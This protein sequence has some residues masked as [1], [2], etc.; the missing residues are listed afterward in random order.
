MT[1]ATQAMRVANVQQRTPDWHVWRRQGV[2]AS[3]A[4]VLTG[5]SK[6]RSPWDYNTPWGLWA[7]AIGLL[8]E[9]DLSGNPNIQR[10]I[11]LEPK[12]R[13]AVEWE[14]KN[15]GSSVFSD[16]LNLE[17]GEYDLLPVCGESVEEPFM[18]ASLDGLVGDIP[19]ELKCP[20]QNVWNDVV[21]NRERSEAV[22]MYWAQLQHQLFV[23]GGQQGVLFFYGDAM[24][25]RMFVFDRDDSFIQNELLPA[26]RDL[27]KNIQECT[28]PDKDPDL[29]VWHP[30]GEDLF[31]WAEV[32]NRFKARRQ[33]VKELEQ[34]LKALK[35]SMRNDEQAL[36]ELMGSWAAAEADG[37]RVRRGYRRGS[38]DWKG[39][40]EELH[41]DGVEEE[42][43]ERHRR[44]GS[45]QVTVTVQGDK[46][47]SAAA[48]PVA[49]QVSGQD[50]NEEPE[51]SFDFEWFF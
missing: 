44:P 34:E 7:A 50:A 18:R 38:V 1:A 43:Q 21:A 13:E 9:P 17:P 28:E 30:E 6:Q 32:S 20:S 31:R 4:P 3:M 40:V 27:W 25:Y 48:G 41:P 35:S 19:F 49:P 10:G 2:S 46:T 37:L 47:S 26:A 45:P 16:G 15:P 36:E 5:R 11:K 8:P 14:L 51:E 12:A 42:L 29:D 39:V 23:T 24:A 33:R 22:Q